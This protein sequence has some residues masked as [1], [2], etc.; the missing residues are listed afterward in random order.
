MSA[1]DAESGWEAFYR[2]NQDRAVSPLLRRALGPELLPRGNGHAIDLGCGAGIE[3]SLLLNAHWN[4][5]A[6]DKEPH[7]IRRVD[8]LAAKGSGGNL[9]TV[10]S[11]FEDLGELPSSALIHAGLS[12]PFCAPASF[13]SFWAS[14]VAALEPGG[15]F[16][17][18][19]FGDRHDWAGHPE[20]SFHRREDVDALCNGLE[21]ELLR[22]IEGDGGHVP[23]HWHRFDLIVRK[24]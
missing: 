4:V 3:T 11:C 1:R 10:V 9:V 23:H 12:L 13:P 21:V 7:A 15:V 20:M 22:E 5:L 2:A 19:L 17:G 18:H 6:I 8:A 16:V 14:I 24:R